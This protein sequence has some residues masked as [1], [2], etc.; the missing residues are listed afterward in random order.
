MTNTTSQPIVQLTR[1]KLLE[2][3]YISITLYGKST[4]LQLL[5]TQQNFNKKYESHM[6]QFQF[7]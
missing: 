2:N 7:F 4:I 5:I 3:F 6:D 1:V